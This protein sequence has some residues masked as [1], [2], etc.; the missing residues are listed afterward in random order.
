[1]SIAMMLLFCPSCHAST[2]GFAHFIK[3]EC[4]F[5]MQKEL[6]FLGMPWLTRKSLFSR[7]REVLK[8]LENVVIQTF[9]RKLIML[10][11]AADLYL[12][13]S[14]GRVSAKPF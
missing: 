6:E 14:Y 3:P 11:A 10:M 2:E 5:L 4:G 9:Y 8:F 13:Q 7:F 12:L 1:M